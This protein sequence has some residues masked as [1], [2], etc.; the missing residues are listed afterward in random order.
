MAAQPTEIRSDRARRVLVLDWPDSL[1]AELPH[2]LLRRRCGC[3]ECR[4][5]RRTSQYPTA[6]DVTVDDIEP[7]G[8]NA[9]QLKFS[10]GHVRGIFPFEYLRA[11][12]EELEPTRDA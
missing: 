1:R 4:Q 2:V 7:Y 8:A 12:A 6:E 9:V 11:L 3:A 10:D 5:L